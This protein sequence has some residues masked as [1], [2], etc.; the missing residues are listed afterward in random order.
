MFSRLY[1]TLPEDRRAKID[2][3]R[4][5]EDKRLSL[6][7]WL[8]FIRALHDVG[9]V[10]QSP[11]LSYGQEGKPFLLDYPDIFF[12]LS[13]S[14]NTVLCA[15]SDS[16]VGCDV[17]KT[18][19]IDLRLAKRFFCPEEYDMIMGF[20]TLNERRDMFF[21]LWT[22]KESFIKAVGLGLQLPFHAFAISFIDDDI[23]VK[24][25]LYKHRSFYFR[26]FF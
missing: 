14:G 4:F 15:I 21:R 17:Q 12:N 26:E 11:Q 23:H 3:M 20:S 7:A 1:R 18:S 6:G 22:L 8:L 2:K 10:T 13:H 25:Q 19:D 24:Q 5:D 16:E 9:V